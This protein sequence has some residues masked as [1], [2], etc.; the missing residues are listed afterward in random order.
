MRIGIVQFPGTN[1]ARETILA[2]RRSGMQ[3]V[4]VLWNEDHALIRS[5][6]AYILAGGFSYEDRSRS[7]V[8]AALDPIMAVIRAENERGKPVLGICN[9]AQILVEAGMVPGP[10]TTRPPGDAI[11]IEE[12]G[13]ADSAETIVAPAVALTTNR[14]IVDGRIIGTGF[15]NAWVTLRAE[16]CDGAERSD[17]TERS[18]TTKRGP[19]AASHLHDDTPTPVFTAEFIR[20]EL[21]RVPAAHAEGRFVVPDAILGEMESGGM[22]AFRYTDEKGHPTPEFPVNPNGSAAN[23]AAI[24]D[25]T[26]TVMAMMPHPERTP[27]GD[28]VF[29][30]LRRYLESRPEA[31]CSTTAIGTANAF[32]PAAD[33]LQYVTDPEGLPGYV[34]EREALTILVKQIITDNT[35]VSVENALNQRGIPAVVRRYLHWELVPDETLTARE[36]DILMETVHASGELYN[37][38][39]ERTIAS[40]ADVGRDTDRKQP[41]MLLVRERD[42]IAGM[43]AHQALVNWFGC[44]GLKTI[45]RG[46]LWTIDPPDAVEA[47]LATHV[48][49]NPIAQEGYRYG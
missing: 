34:P 2:V 14:R 15:Y 36:R 11:A 44:K 12:S 10:G 47:V 39:K 43:E 46:I 5:L 25:R 33:P 8:I 20:G 24:T 28:G 21:M 22:V 38:N 16:R 30:S 45:R 7:G 27:A 37:P 23:I 1:C 13:T 6:D 29:R 26:G 19:S 48:L 3:A 9:G 42:D 18:D 41:F 31:T 49:I 32:E 4:P 17:V 40:P 35:A